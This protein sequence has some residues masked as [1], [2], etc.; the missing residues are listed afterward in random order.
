VP[1]KTKNDDSLYK[2]TTEQCALGEATKAMQ[3]GFK[4]DRRFESQFWKT[5]SLIY[6]I[7]WHNWQH[8]MVALQLVTYFS[9]E[10]GRIA[11]ESGEQ[12]RQ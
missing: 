10:K 8:T 2:A 7:M 9:H 11:A 1:N 5:L 3:V 6:R 4:L 12:N